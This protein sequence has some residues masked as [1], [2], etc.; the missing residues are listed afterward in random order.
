MKKDVLVAVA[1][2]FLIGGSAA[3]ALTNIPSLLKTTQKSRSEQ[4]ATTISPSISENISPK[5]QN[6]ENL[7]TVETPQQESISEEKTVAVVG[8]S[9]PG[10]TVIIDTDL[11]SQVATSAA[12]GTFSG[13]VNLG[14]GANTLYITS[15]DDKGEKTEKTIT[16]FYTPEKL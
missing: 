9:K 5:I 2:G 8:K 7:L 15:Y 16:V 13:K 1:I 14:E 11:E 3:L 6:D 4:I 10:N 12:D